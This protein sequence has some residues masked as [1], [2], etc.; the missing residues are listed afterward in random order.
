[1]MLVECRWLDSTI[2]YL[3]QS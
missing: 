2:R 1:M 3:G